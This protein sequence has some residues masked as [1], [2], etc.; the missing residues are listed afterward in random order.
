MVHSS[1]FIS[2]G[3]LIPRY[4][5]IQRKVL[6]QLQEVL[7]QHLPMSSDREKRGTIEKIEKLRGIEKRYNHMLHPSWQEVLK[8][9]QVLLDQ[10]L[11]TSSD[12][13]K[14]G[15]V[16][17]IEKLRGIEKR[18]NPMFYPSRQEDDGKFDNIIQ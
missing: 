5:W 13:E 14:R 18:Y 11:P 3:S 8:Q 15:T 4:F 16:V 2:K 7:D 9:L 10:H 6:K 1:L 12:R 17:K